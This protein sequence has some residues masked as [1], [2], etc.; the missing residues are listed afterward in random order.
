MSESLSIE[1]RNKLKANFNNFDK[2]QDGLIS[3]QEL[4]ELMK[5]TT[6]SFIE[7]DLQDLL[8]ETDINEKGQ[9]NCKTYID[10]ITKLNRKNDTEDEIIEVFKIF[11]RDNSGL[12][13]TKKIMDIFLKIDENIKEE[14]VLQMIKECDI[15][16]DG[17]LNFEEFSLLMKNK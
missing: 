17:Y 8:N 1:T 14:E 16:Q 6:K 7:A 10:I 9:I 12:I 13:S 4:K 2:D 3:Y 15:D 11:D 5:Q